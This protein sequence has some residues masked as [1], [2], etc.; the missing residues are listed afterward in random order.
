MLNFEILGFNLFDLVM[1][2]LSLV[3]IYKIVKVVI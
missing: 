3:V 2:I 1:S